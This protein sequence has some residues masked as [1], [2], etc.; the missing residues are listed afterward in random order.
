M[1]AALRTL[2]D[3]RANAWSQVQDIQARRE[4]AGY[5]PTDEDGETYTRALD[6]VERLGA[7]IEEEE[8]ADRLDAVMNRPSGDVRSTTP[9]A[10]GGNPADAQEQYARAFDSFARRGMID[11]SPEERALMQRGLV[12]DEEIRAQA[13]TSG[14]AGGY[15]VPTEFWNRLVETL[16]AY[17]G[18]LGVSQVLNTSTGAEILWPTSDGTAVKGA[19]V[20]ENTQHTEQDETFGQ[21]SIKAHL[22]SSKIIRVSYQ[23]LQDSGLD[24][25]TWLP[26]R[27]GERIGRAVADHLAVGTGTGQPKGLITG[28]TL[29]HETA[30]ASKVGYDD[31]V[32]LEH[33]VD[34]AYRGRGRYVLADT[35]LRELRKLKDTTGRPLWVPTVAGGVPSTINGREYTIDNSFPTFADEAAPIVFGD[36]EAAYL[37]RVVNGAQVLRLTERYADYLQVGFLGFQRLDATVQDTAAAAK[38]TVKKAA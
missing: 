8:R 28:L 34:P 26:R 29:S 2:L 31:L 17:G 30:T 37:V 21:A 25:N 20:G 38:L 1:R 27:C 19:I 11:I 12:A 4:A 14:A 24:L 36:I 22:Y 3:Q 13:T 7:Q 5:Q 16:K 9:V 10:D 35:A 15:T 23:L 32:E 33:K 6:E 18:L